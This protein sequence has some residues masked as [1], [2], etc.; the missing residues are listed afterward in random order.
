MLK[1]EV[2]TKVNALVEHL[3]ITSQAKPE[4]M[5]MLARNGKLG[6]LLRIRN[7]VI[8]H[9][10]CTD[11]ATHI[12]GMNDRSG[13]RVTLSEECVQRFLA[14]TVS[15]VLILR[16]TIVLEFTRR[17]IHLIER[18][19]EI[20]PRTPAKHR[21][22]ILAQQALNMCTSVCLIQ[23]RRIRNT[24]L[25]DINQAQRSAAFLRRHLGRADIHTAIDLHRVTRQHL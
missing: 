14:N 13:I 19:L 22:A 15:K 16:A 18:G 6:F 7:A 1:H 20:Q 5:I 3:S 12:M 9:L 2:D 11:H 10:E 8:V 24:R 21:Q 17:K 4:R 23:R 25:Y